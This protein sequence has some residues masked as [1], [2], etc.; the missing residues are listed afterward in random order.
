ML[1][2]FYYLLVNRMVLLGCLND[3][4]KTVKLFMIR[5]LSAAIED[6]TVESDGRCLHRL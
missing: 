3:I 6:F 2:H 4:N 1:R 5:V